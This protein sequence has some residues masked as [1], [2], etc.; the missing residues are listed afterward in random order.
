[1]SAPLRFL[2][3]AMIGW[4]G[5]R[6][7][8]LD[9]LPIGDGFSF[10]RGP[11]AVAAIV[12]TQFPPL[13]PPDLSPLA[14]EAPFGPDQPALAA[15]APGYVYAFPAQAWGPAPAWSSAQPA[16][17]GGYTVL[18]PLPAPLF[19]APLPVLDDW[20]LSRLASAAFPQRRAAST[21]AAAMPAAPVAPKLD[22]LQLSSWALLRGT[23]NQGIGPPPTVGL[24][25]NPMLGGS[26]AG[27][28]LTYA[29]NRALA[30][31]ARMSAPVGSRGGEVAAGVRVTPLR[32]IP[33]SLTAE[34]RHAF[35]RFAGRSAFAVFVEG[36]VYQRPMPWHFSMD[37]Y[38]QAG[39][40]GLRRRDFFADGAMTLTRPVSGRF[41]AGF[42][43]WGGWQ[44]GSQPGVYR[45]DA[46]PRVS[47]RVRDNIRVHG[48]WRQ[49][50][51]G[52][53]EPGSG[54]ALTLAA[55]F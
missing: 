43:L 48:D 20:P 34:R 33:L 39:V 26:Q 12:P 37:A 1:M 47:I 22:R 51:A 45:V 28:R 40:V 23:P 50:L 6:A 18:D 42:G 15:V 16:R 49:R 31:S 19:Y 54:P 8:T 55:D 24:G 53:A 14:A 4:V 46:G 10:A 25:P 7:A 11:P 41:S 21:P 52:R 30:A 38:A 2:G 27:M 17:R 32:A 3:L 29:F 36:G 44:G 13:D 9:Q 35:G 5:L